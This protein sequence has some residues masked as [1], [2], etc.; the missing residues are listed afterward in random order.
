MSTIMFTRPHITV[1]EAVR[2][3]AVDPV[4]RGA[5]GLPL[6][7]VAVPM[8]LI[9]LA[10]PAGRVQ[11]TLASRFNAGVGGGGPGDGGR[12]A[13]AAADR[14]GRRAGPARVIAHSLLVGLPG[15]VAA[16]LVALVVVVAY[17]GYLYPLRPDASF[18]IGHPFSADSRFDHAWGGPTLV[19]AWFVHAC[20]TFGIQAG[21]LLVL[22]VLVRLAGRVTRRIL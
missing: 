10:G 11:R 14:P 9:G 5:T 19:G 1:R 17:S 2:T 16:F 6:A 12:G 13:A 21:C 22:R 18:A 15:L 7:I 4:I 20:V 3:W 8:A